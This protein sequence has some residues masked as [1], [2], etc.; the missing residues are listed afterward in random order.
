MKKLFLTLLSCLLTG[1]TYADNILD[2]GFEYANTD[3][4]VPI[5]WISND[6]SWLCGH[7]D[8]DHNRTA[9]TGDWYAFTNAEDSWMFMDMYMSKQ[10]KYRYSCWA[11]S[12]GSYQLEFWGGNSASPAGMNQL[13]LTDTVN[14]GEYEYYSEYIDHLAQNYQYLGIHAVASTG[15]SYLTID[16]IMVDMVNRYD[17]D[18]IPIEL[19]TVAYP[20]TTV[21]FNYVVKNTGYDELIVFSNGYSDYFTN[22][23]FT[24]DGATGANGATF[25]TEPNQ[26]VMCT[27]TATL[28]PGAP[29]GSLCKL[30]IE[31]TV[32]C[33]CITRL[34]TIWAEVLGSVDDFPV[35]ENFETPDLSGNRWF[36]YGNNNPRWEWTAEGDNFL[37]H[38]NSEGM[39]RFRSSETIKNSLLISPKMK[40]NETDNQIRLYLYRDGDNAGE[41]RINIYCNS[42]TTTHGATLIGT[43]YRNTGLNPATD[44]NGWYEYNL[45]FDCN[46]ATAFIILEAVGDQG[47]DI[48]IDDVS[49]SDE[50]MQPTLTVTEQVLPNGI[51]YPNPVDDYLQIKAEGLMNVKVADLSGK[52]LMSVVADSDNISLNMDNLPSGIYFVSVIT[53][54]ATSTHKI[55]RK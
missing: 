1:L 9:H 34:S 53:K 28:S 33:D 52:I 22:V 20:G 26:A 36:I 47:G 51:M 44:D 30:D 10:L 2:E 23:Q 41:D 46:M 12:D 32:S 42:Y 8:K 16:D 37:P 25:F 29:V 13:F 3:M 14:T 39:L 11:I 55:V 7:F 15:A 43:I 27:C 45:E 24:A 19:D 31:F 4:S 17:L 35:E 54:T 18:I 38:N 49:I 48:Y 6:Q 50:L 40:L 21:T 5:G